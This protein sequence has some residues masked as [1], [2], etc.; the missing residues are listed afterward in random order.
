VKIIERYGLKGTFYLHCKGLNDL[1]SSDVKWLGGLGEVGSHTLKHLDLTMLDLKSA[2]YELLESKNFLERILDKE[3]ETLAYPY[4]RYNDV[5]VELARKAGYLCARTTEPFSL[6]PI[7]DPFRLKVT[8]YTDPHA[9]RSILKAIRGLESPS[10][11]F[12]PWFIKMWDKLASLVIEK[13][14]KKE[15]MFMMHILVHPTFIAKRDDWAR[16]ESLIDI[17]SS[18][19]MI[20]LTVSEFVRLMGRVDV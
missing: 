16:F 14:E 15:G 12:K 6:S 13:L 7:Q 5:V 1:S 8:L 9:L 11:L 4:G 10:L 18:H 19:N 3:I 17:L 2:F 20:N